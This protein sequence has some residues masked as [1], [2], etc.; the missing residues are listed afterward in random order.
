[1]SAVGPGDD[2]EGGDGGESGAGGG[3]GG[4]YRAAAT[5]AIVAA[6]AAAPTRIRLAPGSIASSRIDRPSHNSTQIAARPEL[7]QLQAAEV[8]G[9]S[10][11]IGFVSTARESAS[12]A[13]FFFAVA[14]RART[15][16]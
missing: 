2:G 3:G 5:G 13:F 14:T 8:I 9:R 1:M 12:F 16:R 15:F 7:L 4:G 6:Q 11:M 10:G